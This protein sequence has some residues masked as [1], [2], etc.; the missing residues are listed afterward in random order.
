MIQLWNC[1]KRKYKS[2]REKQENANHSWTA[3][4]R[5]DIDHLYVPRKDELRIL[6][7]IGAYI[8]EIITL[9]KYVEH[10]EDLLLQIVGTH[11][12]NTNSSCFKQSTTLKNLFRV[13]QSK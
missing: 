2:W 7:Q 12:Q 8:A 5:A 6:M 1:I 10:K 9:E 4:S 13:T 11:Q 3:S